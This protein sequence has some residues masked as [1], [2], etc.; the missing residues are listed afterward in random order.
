MIKIGITYLYTILTYGY[1]PAI[2]DDFK[3]L[4]DIQEMGFHYLEMEGLGREH[5]QSLWGRRAEFKQRLADHGVHVHNFCAVDPDLVSLDD[6]TRRAAY[7]RFK[8]SA[9]LGAYLGTETL[10]LASYAPPVSYKG[11]HPYSLGEKY[12]FGDTYNISIPDGFSWDRVW[13]TIV[14]SCRT[15]AQIAE[16]HGLTVIMEPRVGE[17]ICSVD[18]MLRLINDVAMPNFKANFDTAHFCAQRE[19]IPL[20][21]TKL[22]GK[23][24]NMH[25]A[26]NNPISTD[27]LPIGEG[28]IDW[29]EVFRLLRLQGYDGYLGLD[30]GNRPTL[31]DDLRRS[32][33]T[34]CAVAA[35]QG[36]T[37]KY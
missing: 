36:I 26:D 29:D 12:E 15:A 24:A 1:P 34:L 2:E 16:T 27:H 8:Q 30:L 20:A 33:D 10:H 19:N 35:R 9:E 6:A 11:K 17:V 7:E 28:V 5:T 13:S 22:Q 25:V 32:R 37:I 18:S 23:Y 21:L 3:A 31:R 4:A 14:G